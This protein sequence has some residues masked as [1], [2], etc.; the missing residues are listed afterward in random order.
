MDC[1]ESPPPSTCP[2]CPHP[3]SEHVYIYASRHLCEPDSYECKHC[4]CV[5]RR[6]RP[7][8]KD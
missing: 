4:I 7:E 1:R 2:K 6:P 8:V 5:V 3:E